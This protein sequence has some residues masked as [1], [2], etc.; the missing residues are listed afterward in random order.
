MS[1]SEE[2]LVNLD[3]D[4]IENVIAAAGLTKDFVSSKALFKPD[5]YLSEKLSQKIMPKLE[6]TL[7]CDFFKVAYPTFS[8]DGKYVF[9]KND[10][11]NT[12]KVKHEMNSEVKIEVPTVDRS[13]AKKTRTK[14][15]ETIRFNKEEL[16][17]LLKNHKFNR[18]EF[19][20]LHGRSA[21]YINTCM[22]NCRMDKKFYDALMTELK[23]TE[24]V[25]EKQTVDTNG[26]SYKDHLKQLIKKTGYNQTQ[27]S[28]MCGMSKTYISYCIA[29]GNKIN[30]RVYNKIVE[31]A[32]GT[33]TKV[34][35]VKPETKP[36]VVT[37][38]PK[39]ESTNAEKIFKEVIPA[40]IDLVKV[41]I[42]GKNY[43]LIEEDKL[44]RLA[45]SLKMSTEILEYISREAQ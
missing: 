11:Y 45:D 14:T 10:E 4:I 28:E 35:E 20:T 32:N 8:T 39:E 40:K 27:L 9:A 37:E 12:N 43:V 17:E 18:M 16:K 41:S 7:L 15:S 24:P 31:L 2:Y 29:T 6:Y 36:T 26:L 38:L 44:N 1:R 33:A 25:T 23:S 19:C 34:E 22:Q 13:T 21:G 3:V 5:N 42:G 30:D